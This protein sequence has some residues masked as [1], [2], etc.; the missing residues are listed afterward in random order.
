[1]ATTYYIDPDIA[2]SGN[3]L[4]P[5]TAKKTWAEVSMSAGNSYLQKCGTTAAEVVTIGGNGTQASPVTL[6]KYGEGINPIITSSSSGSGVIIAVTKGGIKIENLTIINTSTTVN[7]SAILISGTAKTDW[8]L[9]NLS[10][11]AKSFGVNCSM[12]VTRLS[13]NNISVSALDSTSMANGVYVYGNPSVDVSID[14]YHNIS[15]SGGPI[16]RYT[17]NPTVI[18]SD[19]EQIRIWNASG[20]VTMSGNICIASKI[21]SNDSAMQIFDSDFSAGTVENNN[22]SDVSNG[23]GFYNVVGPLDIRNCIVERCGAGF[24]VYGASGS[25][26]IDFYDCA[27]IDCRGDGFITTSGAHDISFT[28]C[29]SDGC[30]NKTTTAAGDGFTTH[31]GDYNITF[32]NCIAVN[33]TASGWALTGTS[34]GELLNCLAYNN[35]GDWSVE[36]G[37]ALDQVRG[38]IYI[39]VTDVNAVSGY[40]WRIK[41]CIVLNN[42]PVEIFL[43]DANKDLVELDYNCLYERTSGN[44]ATLDS[45]ATKIDWATYHAAYEAH[46]IHA[47][48]LLVDALDGDYNL[49]SISPCLQAGIESGITTDYVGNPVYGL[50]IGPFSYQYT[51]SFAPISLPGPLGIDGQF[52][53]TVFPI[54][55]FQAPLGAPLQLVLGSAPID[56]SALV[57]TAKIR[58]GDKGMAVYSADLDAAGILRADRVVGA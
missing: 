34:S 2:A 58:I 32:T 18:N 44:L 48:P 11:T 57:P 43:G 20:V 53:G 40:S 35:A 9:N 55:N 25:D 30:G 27:A 47:D 37:G 4:T 6:G 49:S 28:R 23:M 21:D 15:N 16:V 10:V 51:R 29:I 17:V 41:N 39:A 1:M 8:T 14:G 3:G 22:I 38:G 54:G 45:L 5:A 46:S 7:S 13:I 56:L 24:N 19:V 31:L 33:N 26:G 50:P 52:D 42:Y 12:P 36:G